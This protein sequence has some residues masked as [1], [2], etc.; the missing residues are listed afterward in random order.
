VQGVGSFVAPSKTESTVLEIRSIAD[1][2]RRRGQQYRCRV[3]QLAEAHDSRCNA[4]LGLPKDATHFRSVLVHYAGDVPVQLEDRRVNPAF[5]PDYLRQD[6]TEVTPN[7][8][9]MSIGSLQYAEHVFEA[10]VP[11]AS[12]ARH[13]NLRKSE[14]CIVLRRR[15][16]SLGI[17]ASFAVI[18]SASSRY[19]YKGVFGSPP[20]RATALPPL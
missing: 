7:E 5:S 9:L 20:P 3:V 13:L 6:F 11:T 18:T 2:I 12:V 15:T 10:E 4:I 14:P 16:W 1:E 8:H 19:R 17:V